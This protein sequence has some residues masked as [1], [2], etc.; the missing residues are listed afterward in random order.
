MT[1]FHDSKCKPPSSPH[2]RPLRQRLTL[3]S[4]TPSQLPETCHFTQAGHQAGAQ[5]AASIR[6]VGQARHTAAIHSPSLRLRSLAAGV[7]YWLHGRKLSS[8]V[9]STLAASPAS[10][11]SKG[12][13][14]TCCR[15]E[16]RAGL[17]WKSRAGCSCTMASTSTPGGRFLASCAWLLASCCVRRAGSAVRKGAGWAFT[18]EGTSQPGRQPCRHSTL[19]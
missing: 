18:R 6:Q 3:F 1:A 7:W 17:L 5:A 12:R 14:C 15:A 11:G 8:R 10:R 9:L 13:A 2:A 4:S 16:C 19:R